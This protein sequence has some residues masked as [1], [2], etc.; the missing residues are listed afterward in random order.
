[1]LPFK[2][3]KGKGGGSFANHRSPKV[4]EGPNAEFQ[5]DRFVGPM[6]TRDETA[7]FLI[8]TRDIKAGQFIRVNYGNRFLQATKTNL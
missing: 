8:A 5:C 6:R 4:G 3:L 2:D 7:L 1:M